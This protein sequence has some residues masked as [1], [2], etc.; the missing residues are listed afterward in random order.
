M[1]RIIILGLAGWAILYVI[2]SLG[3][4]GIVAIGLMFWGLVE[5]GDS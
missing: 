5:W 2:Y 3:L 1:K 4:L